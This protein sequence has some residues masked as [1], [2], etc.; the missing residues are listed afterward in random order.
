MELQGPFPC[1]IFNCYLTYKILTYLEKNTWEDKATDMKC[2]LI[3]HD[4]NQ[5]WARYVGRE[6]ISLHG[7]QVCPN[8]FLNLTVRSPLPLLSKSLA[9]CHILSWHGVAIEFMLIQWPPCNTTEIY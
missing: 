2:Q 9:V 6:N 8:L 5:H 7:T 1:I 3:W 4:P